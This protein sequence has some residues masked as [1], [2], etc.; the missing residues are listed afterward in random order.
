MWRYIQFW[1]WDSCSYC[2]ENVFFMLL[3]RLVYSKFV[4]RNQTN[5]CAA[6]AMQHFKWTVEFNVSRQPPSLTQELQ[7][8]AWF[9]T[10]VANYEREVSMEI[11]TWCI[12]NLHWFGLVLKWFWCL[13]LISHHSYTSFSTNIEF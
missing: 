2:V 4:P 13:L 6:T 1:Q 5:C 3:Y 11:D 8:Q 10:E 12:Y 7:T 9:I